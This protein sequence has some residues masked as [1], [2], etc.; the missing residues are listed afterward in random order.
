MPILQHY[1]PQI[2]SS[3]RCRSSHYNRP[4]A[5]GAFGGGWRLPKM[6]KTVLGCIQQCFWFLSVAENLEWRRFYGHIYVI[7]SNGQRQF[8]SIFFGSATPMTSS[9]WWRVDEEEKRSTYRILVI[10]HQLIGIGLWEWHHF[11]RIISTQSVPGNQFFVKIIK[12]NPLPHNR[13]TITVF[14]GGS[15]SL[16]LGPARECE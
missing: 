13:S 2:H 5:L 16:T 3:Y 7:S 4:S 15:L 8:S 10:C 1:H 11:S 14:V 9:K 6:V 12:F